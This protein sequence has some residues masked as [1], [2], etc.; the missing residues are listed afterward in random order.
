MDVVVR[1]S[2]IATAGVC[3]GGVDIS[4]ARSTIAGGAPASTRV[5]TMAAMPSHGRWNRFVHRLRLEGTSNRSLFVFSEHNFVRKYAKIIIE[6][7]YP[8]ER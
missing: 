4:R 1:S 5:V 7:G 2:T 3:H 6:W 8:F